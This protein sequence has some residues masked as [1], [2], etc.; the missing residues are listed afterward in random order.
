MLRLLNVRRAIQNG[1]LGLAIVFV[2]VSGCGT[3]PECKIFGQVYVDEKPAEG[4]YVVFY[5]GGTTDTKT[6]ASAAARTDATGMF[7]SRVLKPGTYVITAFWPSVTITEGEAIEGADQFKGRYRNLHTPVMSY[8]LG[9]GNNT[10]P[11]LK[12]SLQR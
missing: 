5:A 12:L 8:E 6:P 2:L 9:P 3:P 10:L 11:Q 4:V 7:E 1:L